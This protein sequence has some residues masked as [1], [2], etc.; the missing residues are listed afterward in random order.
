[1]D[2]GLEKRNT[3][4]HQPGGRPEGLFSIDGV[5]GGWGTSSQLEYNP[6]NISVG[7]TLTLHGP[8]FDGL[9]FE[10]EQILGTTISHAGSTYR[11]TDYVLIG[12]MSPETACLADSDAQVRVRLRC[13]DDGY[14]GLDVTA[15]Q[16]QH[17][18]QEGTHTFNNF[19]SSSGLV[20]L[21]NSRGGYEYGFER[22]DG[23]R[24]VYRGHRAVIGGE[25]SDGSVT[26]RTVESL[27]YSRE[28]PDG[29]GGFYTQWA[30]VE[31]N[32]ET[33]DMI[34]LFGWSLD[35]SLIESTGS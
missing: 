20:S 9:E 21:R 33:R 34:T 1:M 11:L 8:D 2:D 35:P 6:L 10:V 4:G 31:H 29:E 24:D 28:Q 26:N 7:S 30:L 13:G 27:D 32:P 16:A 3:T 18:E 22:I 14:G 17:L 23:A 12:T 15:F 25:G 19:A 5:F